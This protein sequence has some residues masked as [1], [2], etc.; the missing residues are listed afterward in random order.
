L[1]QENVQTTKPKEFS[2]DRYNGSDRGDD[3]L[4]S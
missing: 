1:E 4:D 3:A 2:S